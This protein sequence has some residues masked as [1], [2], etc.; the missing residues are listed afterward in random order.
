MIRVTATREG[1]VGKQTACGWTID[2]VTPFVALP[3]E[4]ALHRM[5]R[6]SN[7]AAGKSILAAVLDV[8]PWNTHDPYVFQPATTGEPAAPGTP[9]IRPLAESGVSLSGR[10]TNGAGIDL[11]EAVHRALG[12]TQDNQPVDW[13]FV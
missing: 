12:F 2:T 13:E 1:L 4:R 9:E 11:G 5:V 7:P 10:G 8:G 6:V 3:H